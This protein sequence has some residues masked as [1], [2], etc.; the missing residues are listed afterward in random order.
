LLDVLLFGAFV[1]DR[2]LPAAF[3]EFAPVDGLESVFDAFDAALD[4]VVL[5]LAI[6]KPPGQGGRLSS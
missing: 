3:L 1:C 4:P 5:D 6:C 2:A